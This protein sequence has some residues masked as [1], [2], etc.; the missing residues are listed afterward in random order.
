MPA[1][2]APAPSD[3]R[4]T[5][6][7]LPVNHSTL[8]EPTDVA[9]AG[10]GNC[11]PVGTRVAEFEITGTVG[12]GG[13]GIVYLAYDHSLQREVALKEYMPGMLAC[14]GTD[15]SVVVRSKR[16]QDP[17]VTGLRRF[18]NEA[19]LLAQ[20]DHPALIK[21]HRFWEQN[22]TGYMA[23][24]YYEG[25][26][27]KR[28]IDDNPGFVTQ[29]WLMVM[30]QSVLEAL[31]A[32]YRVQVL[33]R[34]ISPENIM[35]QSNGE[36]VL[37][38]FGAARQIISDMTQALTVILKPGYA[39]IEQYADDPSMLQGPWTD[40]YALAAVMYVAV[41]GSAP[42]S[43]VARLIQDPITHL[44]G[45]TYP[46]YSVGFLAAIDQ[47]L[48]VRPEHRPQS[49][50]AFRA[51]LGLPEVVLAPPRASA[52]GGRSSSNG[53][54]T[55]RRPAAG[56]DNLTVQH[57]HRAAAV[58]GN[59]VGNVATHTI[60]LGPARSINAP[61]SAPTSTPA[62]IGAE[63]VGLRPV[64]TAAARSRLYLAGGAVLLVLAAS[65]GYRMSAS[66]VVAAGTTKLAATAPAEQLVD[67]ET[68]AWETL[69][70]RSDLNPAAINGFIQRYPN[71]RLTAQA[72]S[73]L[74]SITAAATTA[75]KAAAVTASAATTA[76]AT[77]AKAAPNTEAE[78]ASTAAAKAAA[79]TAAAAE[80][81]PVSVSL[82]IKPW[83]NV[84]VDG[85]DKGVSPP[86]KRLSLTP[87][88]HAI[89][90]NNPNFPDYVSEIEVGKKPTAKI[91]VDFAPGGN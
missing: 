34:D 48:A 8:E 75:E 68:L 83:G 61:A 4:L 6:T 69:I 36:A 17:F 73:R 2:A 63:S 10:S 33:H 26:T 80:A 29:P 86:L 65:V 21:I 58:T 40:I 44:A 46:G 41:T 76:V 12:E 27:L 1:I 82:S 37:L 38:D 59:T 43:S 81:A 90:V 71:G 64:A 5:T 23:M 30:L 66:P 91:T 88:K 89:R 11:L 39:P 18:I 87:G 31:E 78:S 28:I 24:R 51:L 70:Q 55:E 9:L 50:P 62:T 32:L 15:Q 45:G 52:P 25:Q 77:D 49:I 20:F 42:P 35:I 13:F 56:Q 54:P 57:S 16:Q 19:R 47:G 67:E 7:R 14:R 72:R 53:V 22:G 60:S 3:S 74:A 79:A 84:S 85:V